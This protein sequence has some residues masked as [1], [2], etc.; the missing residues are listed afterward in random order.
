[1][2]A[3]ASPRS[4]RVHRRKQAQ[5]SYKAASLLWPLGFERRLVGVLAARIV[6]PQHRCLGPGLFDL[7]WIVLPF[8]IRREEAHDQ[9][10]PV[11]AVARIVQ[12][13][14][15]TPVHPRDPILARSVLWPI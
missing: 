9:H 6:G 5:A 4:R 15:R 11:R 12:P 3:H 14:A 1:M 13:L 8:R 2:W 7:P 10:P